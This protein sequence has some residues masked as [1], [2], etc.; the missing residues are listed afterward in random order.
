MHPHN[1]DPSE[2]VETLEEFCLNHDGKWFADEIHEELGWETLEE[3]DTTEWEHDRMRRFHFGTI[4]A[5][6][7]IARSGSEADPRALDEG[8]WE[9]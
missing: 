5:V 4:D 8:Y 9:L 6:E 3:Q 7:L 1:M 2:V